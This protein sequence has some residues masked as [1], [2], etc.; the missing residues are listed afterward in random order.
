MP[1]PAAPPIVA[2]PEKPYAYVGAFLHRN[3]Y[4]PSLDE[5]VEGNRIRARWL[6]TGDTISVFVPDSADLASTA[7]TLIRFK[8][9]QIDAARALGA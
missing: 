2:T 8:G 1:E 7:D 9:A 3:E 5:V 4:D 6:A